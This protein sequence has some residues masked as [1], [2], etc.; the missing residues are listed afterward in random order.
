M[1]KITSVVFVGVSFAAIGYFYDL[2]RCG[3]AFDRIRAGM[4]L[5]QVETMLGCKGNEVSRFDSPF[6]GSTAAYDFGDARVVIQGGVV[7]MKVKR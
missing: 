4:T 5:T 7:S 1:K 6:I 3:Y 2:A